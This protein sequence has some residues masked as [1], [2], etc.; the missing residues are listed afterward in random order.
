LASYCP[1]T[2]RFVAGSYTTDS[3]G[4]LPFVTVFPVRFPNPSYEYA[5]PY[6][7]LTVAAVASRFNAS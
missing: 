1:P 5:C 2:A 4:A 6:A 3:A 7:L